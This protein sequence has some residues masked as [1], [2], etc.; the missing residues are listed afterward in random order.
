M[1]R[2]TPITRPTFGEA[3]EVLKSNDAKALVFDSP[4]VRFAAND[5]SSLRLLGGRFNPEFYG[6]AVPTGSPLREQIDVALLEL[7]EEGTF[8]ALVARWF[9]KGE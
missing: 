7:R 3:L 6:I 4:T 2:I 8:D 5:D 1:S 9:G